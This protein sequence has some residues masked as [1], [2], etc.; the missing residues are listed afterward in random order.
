[1]CV[2]AYYNDP[3][4]K[5][6]EKRRR[7]AHAVVFPKSCRGC[8]VSSYPAYFAT[9]CTG[10]RLD[11][12]NAGTSPGQNASSWAPYRRSPWGAPGWRF[13]ITRSCIIIERQHAIVTRNQTTPT[14]G[15]QDSHL[16]IIPLNEK[17]KVVA[18]D[19]NPHKLMPAAQQPTA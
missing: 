19:I 4:W 18:V 6:D 5:K 8:G 16:L 12:T 2:D 17:T 10:G 9:V 13:E 15:E 1:M 3:E 14:Q 7:S 11:N